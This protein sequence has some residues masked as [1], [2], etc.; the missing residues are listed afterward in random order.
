MRG[1]KKV[2]FIDWRQYALTVFL[3]TLIFLAAVLWVTS[4]IRTYFFNLIEE[5]TLRYA[6]SYSHSI[7][8]NQEAYQTINQLLEE[9]IMEAS[10]AAALSYPRLSNEVLKKIADTFG[11]DEIYCYNPKG[12]IIYTNGK[13]LGW[14]AYMGHP[15]YNFM[16]GGAESLVEEIRTDTET[17]NIINMATFAFLIMVLYRRST[18]RSSA[19]F[20]ARS[21]STDP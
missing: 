6:R 3:V 16:I 20:S 14:K 11:V 5:E 7:S 18:L 19:T 21:K 13:Y 17:G 9:K 4:A 10:Q 1:G 8:K 15:V 2:K 12:E